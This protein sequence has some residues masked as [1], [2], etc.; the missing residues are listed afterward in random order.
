M[1]QS[2]F[3]GHCSETKI[4]R[5]ITELQ[6]KDLSLTHSMIP[7]GSCTMKLNAAS[8]MLPVSWPEF[9]NIHPFAPRNQWAG[10]EAMFRSL[11][12]WLSQ[13]TG[14]HAVSLQPNAGSQGEYTGLMVIKAYHE[15]RGQSNRN[16]CL[17]PVSAHGT[18]PASAIVAGLKTVPVKCLANGD[19][20]LEDLKARISE[21]SQHLAAMP[22]KFID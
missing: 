21:H 16:I 20:D 18:N 1:E 2:V 13:I 4:L 5:Y 12:S 9:A 3:H 14:F 10:Y 15:Q 22:L 11:E 19:I 6:S 7:L 17:I 8:E